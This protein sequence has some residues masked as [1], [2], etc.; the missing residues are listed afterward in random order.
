[1]HCCVFNTC[2]FGGDDDTQPSASHVHSSS[3]NNALDE[4]DEHTQQGTANAGASANTILAQQRAS[5]LHAQLIEMIQSDRALNAHGH[6]HHHGHHSHHSH[7]TVNSHHHPEAEATAPEASHTNPA[8]QSGTQ[9]SATV[10]SPT[11]SGGTP[12]AAVANT[13]ASLTGK[14]SGGT[15]VPDAVANA[16]AVNP[17][18]TNADATTGTTSAVANGG[19]RIS[20]LR[21][22][23]PP[24]IAGATPLGSAMTPVVGSP[25]AASTPTSRTTSMRRNTSYASATASASLRRTTLHSSKHHHMKDGLDDDEEENETEVQRREKAQ[26]KADVLLLKRV[27]MV[28]QATRYVVRPNMTRGFRQW[29]IR[30]KHFVKVTKMLNMWCDENFECLNLQDFVGELSYHVFILPFVGIVSFLLF[31]QYS[32]VIF[33]SLNEFTSA[34]SSC[35]YH[36]FINLFY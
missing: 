7:H 25:T 23:V 11:A 28:T 31:V 8:T 1:M 10:Q 26:Y 20:Q 29:I 22:N 21:L 13:S 12:S 3:N 30:R 15:Q 18:N 35:T 14:S 16:N 24:A 32:F 2:R 5:R 34:F 17:S 9:N 27:Y 33:L 6:H 19:R 4:Q 36:P